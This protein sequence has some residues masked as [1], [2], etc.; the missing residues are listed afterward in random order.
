MR[1]TNNGGFT[2]NKQQRRGSNPRPSGRE[3]CTLPPRH[4]STI[5]YLKVMVSC[6]KYE[7]HSSTATTPQ[8]N[9]RISFTRRLETWDLRKLIKDV[10]NLGKGRVGVQNFRRQILV[11]I[12]IRKT[13]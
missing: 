9:F 7:K 5:Q 8:S 13:Q 12:V 6:H 2:V 1:P 11:I 3:A 4:G 10:R